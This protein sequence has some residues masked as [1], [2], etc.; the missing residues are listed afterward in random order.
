MEKYYNTNA[1]LS[2]YYTCPTVLS[3]LLN[4]SFFEETRNFLLY[5]QVTKTELIDEKI[6][7]ITC[8][9]TTLKNLNQKI[10]IIYETVHFKT[11]LLDIHAFPLKI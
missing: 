7:V 2:T 11:H 6:H 5:Y 4:I 3:V 1:V 8:V 9:L 10:V